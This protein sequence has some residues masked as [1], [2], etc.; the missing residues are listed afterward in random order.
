MTVNDIA[1]PPLLAQLVSK[2]Q[3][4]W[5]DFDSIDTWLAEQQGDHVLLFAGDPVRFPEALD[6]AVVLPELQ[7][8]SATTGRSFAL[9]V[10]VPDC[11]EELAKK[12]GSQ[13]WPTLMF[14]RDGHY[15]TTLSGM[16]DWTDYLAL[17]TQALAAPTSRAPTI[18]IPLVSSTAGSTCH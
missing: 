12:F 5:L 15:V 3:A 17:V 11:A 7:K 2:H 8:A 1:A 16:H 9:A 10:A 14:F 18:G 13:R 4:Q 6:V